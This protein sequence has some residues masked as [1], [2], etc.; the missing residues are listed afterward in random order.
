VFRGKPLRDL[1]SY[2]IEDKVIIHVIDTRNIIPLITVKIKKPHS[3][4]VYFYTLQSSE[5][6]GDFIANNI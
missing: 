1:Q 2:R 5:L 3:D 6:I 4:S